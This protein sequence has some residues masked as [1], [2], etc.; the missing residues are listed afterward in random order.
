MGRQDQKF[1][2]ILTDRDLYLIE[3]GLIELRKKYEGWKY[4]LKC[5]DK[6]KQINNLIK[7]LYSTFWESSK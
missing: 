3:D 7:K 5:L 2:G 6:V 4:D 1:E